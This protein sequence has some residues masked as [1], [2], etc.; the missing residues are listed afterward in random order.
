MYRRCTRAV[1]LPAVPERLRAGLTVHAEANQLTVDDATRFWLT[2][3]ENLPAPTALGRAF[4]RRANPADPD[5][6]HDVLVA[7]LATH[8]VVVTAGDKRGLAALSVPLLAAAVSPGPRLGGADEGF[9]VSGFPGEHNAPGTFFI[10]LGPDPA[11]C[12]EAVRQAVVAA[13]S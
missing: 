4:G 12:Y 10:G 11:G 7:L 3:S 9:S 13:K 8:L 5:A 6:E 2:H 1:A